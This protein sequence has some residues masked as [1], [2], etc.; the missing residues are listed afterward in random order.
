MIRHSL[1]IDD[2][3]PVE[4]ARALELSTE[5]GPDILAVIRLNNVDVQCRLDA[6]HPVNWG[7]EAELMS[8]MRKVVFFDP[9]S[10]K[11]IRP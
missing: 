5:T 11:R 10:E 2:L 9:D 4:L 6:E 3:T 7:E 1:E 8:D